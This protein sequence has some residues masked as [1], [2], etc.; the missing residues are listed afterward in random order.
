M[1]YYKGS[2]RHGSTYID[3]NTKE[4][5]CFFDVF[6]LILQDWRMANCIDMEGEGDVQD[7]GKYR[8]ITL[9]SHVMK[10]LERILGRRI[11]KSVE[12]EIR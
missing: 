3:K 10:V 6:D 11:R 4:V 1:V 8:D 9:L 7:L 5:V 2:T 12:M